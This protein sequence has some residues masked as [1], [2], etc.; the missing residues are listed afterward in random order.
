LQGQVIVPGTTS[1]QIKV[2]GQT[3]GSTGA[4]SPFQV[5]KVVA[6]GYDGHDKLI[7]VTVPF[8]DTRDY[9]AHRPLP[10]EAYGGRGNDTLKGNNWNYGEK[11][12]LDGGSDADRLEGFSGDDKLLGG[13]GD[14]QLVGGMG[15]DPLDG[16]ANNDW[17][18]AD[19]G[20]SMDGGTFRAL[21]TTDAQR[22]GN[23]ILRGGDGTDYM[24]GEWGNDILYGQGGN[25][26][27]YGG[28]G[29]D[30]LFGGSH[31]DLLYGEYGAD[32]YL[33]WVPTPIDL[34]YPTLHG[35]EAQD[36][37]VVFRMGTENWTPG[38]IERVDAALQILHQVTGNTTL[39]EQLGGASVTFLKNDGSGAGFNAGGTITLTDFVMNGNS[40][41][42]I[43]Y[44]LH[45]IGHNWDEESPIYTAHLAVNGWTQTNPN[46]SAFTR[47]D[48]CGETWWFRTGTEF[49]SSYATTHPLDDFAE[50]FAA[51]FLQRAGLPWYSSDGL[52]AAAVPNKIALMDGW[53]LSISS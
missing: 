27:L 8:Y 51:Y 9:S 42:E 52:G 17:L 12:H 48:K 1:I 38:E 31:D 46:S 4:L 2:N 35:V 29:N 13:S 19:N 23:D 26:I 44:I 10:L 14:D 45:E 24:F 34:A 3:V 53:A 37:T 21:N 32:R 22:G 16:G 25:D 20:T 7:V 36:A 15:G 33:M 30:G 41:W 47:I 50:T 28:W 49:A 39:L 40:T 43:G 5:V 6:N 11:D 18:F